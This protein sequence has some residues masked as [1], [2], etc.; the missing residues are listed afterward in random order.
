MH[1]VIKRFVDDTFKG[2][3]AFNLKSGKNVAFNIPNDKILEYNQKFIRL[4]RAG[5]IYYINFE[6]VEE[7]T[8]QEL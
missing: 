7:I 6:C 8:M 1:D 4:E 3:L 5:I 2:V